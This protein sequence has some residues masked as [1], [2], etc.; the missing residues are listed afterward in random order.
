MSKHAKE[1]I[2]TRVK[3]GVGTNV[4]FN[5][6]LFPGCVCPLKRIYLE[7]LHYQTQLE[8]KIFRDSSCWDCQQLWFGQRMPRRWHKQKE[9]D[10]SLEWKR[11][12]VTLD[13]C[14][15]NK[16]IAW[17]YPTLSWQVSEGKSKNTEAPGE[18]TLD[19]CPR[20]PLPAPHTTIGKATRQAIVKPTRLLV[21]D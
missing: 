3:M 21:R 15:Y 16:S 1:Y 19:V 13:A 14:P 10:Q 4:Q 8:S 20:T 17:G 5:V 11:H 7:P 9:M 6:C 12:W 18:V 2:T